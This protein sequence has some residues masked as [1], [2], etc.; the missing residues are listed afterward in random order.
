MCLIV[1]KARNNVIGVQGQLPWRLKNDMAFFK[2]ATMGKPIIMGRKTWESF[3][4]RPL[5]GRQNI[6]LSK[7]WDYAAIGARVYSS[8]GPALNAARTIAISEGKDEV[9]VIGGSMIYERAL[10]L[11]DRLYLTEVDAAPD[12]DAFFPGIEE[13]QWAEVWS[14]A[15]DADERNE[16]AFRIRRLDCAMSQI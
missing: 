9:F 2:E 15:Y 6:V 4:R 1:A 7:D 12:G 10:P 16:F 3:P 5:P 13:E 14:R 11:A 8:L